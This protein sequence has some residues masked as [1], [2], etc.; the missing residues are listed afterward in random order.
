MLRQAA[1]GKLLLAAM[2]ALAC[3][4]Q[5]WEAGVG[6][7][8]GAY[9][10]VS[11]Y[12]PAGKVMAG[13]RNRFVLTALLAEDLYEHVSGEVRYTYHDGDPFLQAGT[14]KANI[15]GQSHAFHYDLLIHARPREAKVRPYLAVG[16]GAKLYRVTGPAMPDQALGQIGRLAS[17]DELKPLVTG[18]GGVRFRL[19][20]HLA[21]RVDFLDY[22][23]AFPKKVLQPAPLGTARGIFH[24][25]TPMIVSSSVF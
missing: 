24:Q 16:I 20:E 11:I 8:Y 5:T 1:T 23:T 18:G 10:N 9:R 17:E 22:I 12:A 21:L 2:C 13:F 3:E 7:G 25:F 19:L 6:V 15:Q 4:A 14:L